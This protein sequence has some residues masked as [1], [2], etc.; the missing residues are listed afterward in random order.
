[1]FRQRLQRYSLDIK[2]SLYATMVVF[3]LFLT[4]GRPLIADEEGKPAENTGAIDLSSMSIEDLMKIEVTCA[5]KT[6]T[7]VSDSPAFV[8][9]I[10]QDDIHRFGYRTLGEVLERI[11]GMYVSSDRNYDYIGVRGIARPGD[12]NTRVLLLVDGHRINDPIYDCAAIGEDFAVDI[13][14]IDRI[15]VAKGPGSALWGTNAILG[16]I[17]VVTKKSA[18]I[19]SFRFI[20]EYGSNK[21]AKGFLE[22]ADSYPNGLDVIAAFSALSCRGE[23]SIYFPEF[24]DPSTN[25][26][27]AENIDDEQA[28]R[29]F[30]AASYKNLSL[31]YSRGYRRKTVPTA[32]FGTIFNLDG[33]YTVDKREFLE[34]TYQKTVRPETNGTALLRLN[35]D[36]YQYHGDYLYD[37]GE[38]TPVVQKDLGDSK[39]WSAEMRYSEQTSDKLALIFGLE[40]IDMYKVLQENHDDE[41][42]YKQYVNVRSSNQLDSIY[43]QGTLDLSRKFHLVAGTRWDH[44]SRSGDAWSPRL[45]LLYEASAQSTFKFLFG[46]AFRAPNEYERNYNAPDWEYIPNPNLSPE[47]STT[48]ELVWDYRVNRNSRMVVS[49]F[50]QKIADIITQTETEDGAIQFQNLDSAESRGFEFSLESRADDGKSG[51]LAFAVADAIDGGTSQRLSNSPCFVGAAGVSIPIKGSRGFISPQVK[52]IGRRRTLSGKQVPPSLTFDLTWYIPDIGKGY[53]L[54]FGGYNIFDKATYSPGSTEHVQDMI[55]RCGR[56]FRLL[57]SRSF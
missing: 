54:S 44:Y 3:A 53:T 55:P 18:G 39:W 38:D 24:D 8:T 30:V 23:K 25:N 4:L 2:C 26:G 15:E 48:Y 11:P 22:Y 49:L 42:Y 50:S 33:T 21:R 37:Y 40:H 17:N 52:Y 9:V 10:T 32:S 51:Y 43:A 29:A 36:T 1:M 12:Y 41:P 35:Y 57:L 45:A 5:T 16:V 19:R 27:V 14:S 46:K 28:H 47:R 13:E 6:P 31:L 34:L 7:T 20:P 56:T